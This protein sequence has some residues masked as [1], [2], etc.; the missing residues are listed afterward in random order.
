VIAPAQ[1]VVE[2]LPVLREHHVPMRLARAITK[3]E[4]IAIFVAPTG[5]PDLEQQAIPICAKLGQCTLI[6]SDK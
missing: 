1:V 3:S 6:A 4:R 2:L 5:T